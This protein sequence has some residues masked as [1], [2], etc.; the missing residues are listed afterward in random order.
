LLHGPELLRLTEGI[1]GGKTISH[2]PGKA[3]D[4]LRISAGTVVL[5]SLNIGIG[6]APYVI[7]E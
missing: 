7:I 2:L 3:I 1:C 5:L 4:E 6:F